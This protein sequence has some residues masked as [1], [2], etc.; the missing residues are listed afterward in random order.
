[1][2]R[3]PRQEIAGGVH[4][5]FARGNRREDIYLDDADREMYLAMLARVVAREGWRLL[6]YCLMHN[7]MHLLV[8]T[9]EPNLGDGMRRLHGEYAQTFNRRHARTGHVFQGRFGSTPQK[10]DGQLWTTA[11]YIALN[12]VEAGLCADPEDWP[13][14]SYRSVL[15]GGAPFWLDVRRL[16][17]YLGGA[18]GDPR[19]RY[20][21]LVGDGLK[22]LAQEAVR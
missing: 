9:P 19:R 4:H 18:G 13:W 1:M 12:P 20:A 5:V 11:G 22:R 16:L 17:T 15:A 14:A 8:E 10:N 6:A 21:Q 2:P 7:H 3:K